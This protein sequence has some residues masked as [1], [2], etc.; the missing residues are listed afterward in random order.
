MFSLF[1]PPGCKVEMFHL[2]VEAV[3]THRD[4]P[5]VSRC[6]NPAENVFVCCLLTKN[7]FQTR[8]LAQSLKGSLCLPPL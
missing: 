1:Y 2:N 8:R 4:R 3:N 6:E 7:S 5:L